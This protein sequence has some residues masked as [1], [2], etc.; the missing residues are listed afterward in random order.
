M[1]FS[2]SLT[3]LLIGFSVATIAVDVAGNSAQQQQE[4]GEVNSP[5]STRA[6]YQAAFDAMSKDELREVVA[7]MTLNVDSDPVWNDCITAELQSCGKICLVTRKA[8]DSRGELCDGGS[9]GYFNLLR[10]SIVYQ[11]RFNEY[12]HLNQMQG[13]VKFDNADRCYIN[14]GCWTRQYSQ[15]PAGC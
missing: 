13:S 4:T 14:T 2:L 7:E 5:I 12:V 3:S 8:R 6:V 10:A 9:N 15:P 1:K 11:P